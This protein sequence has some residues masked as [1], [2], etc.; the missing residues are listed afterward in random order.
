M[1]ATNCFHLD[2]IHGELTSTIPFEAS[3]ASPESP[4]HAYELIRLELSYFVECFEFRHGHKPDSMTIQLEACRIII[5]SEVHFLE[6]CP[7]AG[8]SWLRDLIMFDE[9]IA[10]Q[11]Q[12]LP[13]RTPSEGRLR[14]LEILGQKTLFAECPLESRLHQ[15]ILVAQ[16]GNMRNISNTDLQAAACAIITQIH[17]SLKLPL[18]DF[19]FHWMIVLARSSTA[20]LD[21]VRQRA[22]LPGNALDIAHAFCAFSTDTCTPTVP[23]TKTCQMGVIG[24]YQGL[25]NPENDYPRGLATSGPNLGR[26]AT[27]SHDADTLSLSRLICAHLSQSEELEFKDG[28]IYDPISASDS[29]QEPSRAPVYATPAFADSVSTEQSTATKYHFHD[30]NFQKWLSLELSRWV[31]AVMSSHNPRRRIPS[32]A[33]IQ[34]QA[35]SL[36]YNK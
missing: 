12:F 16:G 26:A 34:R 5:A 2:L 14:S 20:W 8:S 31:S 36:L 4:R 6:D 33:E 1:I 9:D 21:Q 19:V 18:T 28:Q 24:G 25:S 23:G 30:P 17:T 29:A 32:D 27:D 11:A 13:L 35:R 22:C 3:T 15:L 7:I 10:V